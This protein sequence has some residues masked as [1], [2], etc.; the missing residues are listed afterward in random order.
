[1]PGLP[2]V[3]APQHGWCEP[4]DGGE[5]PQPVPGTRSPL[6]NPV[7]REVFPLRL[8]KRSVLEEAA[9]QPGFKE[10]I[11]VLRV[12][13]HGDFPGRW[14]AGCLGGWHI[15][16]QR[17][18]V[19]GTGW[20][21]L[22][23]RRATGAGVGTLLAGISPGMGTRRGAS[24]PR[25]SPTRAPSSPPTLQ[26]QR[27]E[28]GD[29]AVTKLGHLHPK[30]PPGVGGRHAHTLPPR[31]KSQRYPRVGSVTGGEGRTSGDPR[32]GTAPPPV[33]APTPPEPPAAPPGAGI[34]A[35]VPGRRD[36]LA[37]GFPAL[38][39]PLAPRA[40]G[41]PAA[42][43]ERRQ[44]PGQPRG[45]PEP[46]SPRAGDPPGSPLG[47]PRAPLAPHSPASRASGSSSQ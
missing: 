22:G 4:G 29:T 17:P 45:V 43:G 14:P 10:P 27:S 34:P 33:P 35:P 21:Q 7:Y 38:P 23:D 32:G 46:P 25:A 31:R 41:S 40:G 12:P 18:T 3:Q 11:L 24:C 2:G 8:R 9:E 42:T 1:M 19:L 39:A 47:D 6:N 20:W 37:Q 36:P 13:G 28:R 16:R 44:P 5:Q 15:C 30:Q 26:P